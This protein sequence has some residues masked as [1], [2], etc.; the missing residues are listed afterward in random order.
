MNVNSN[1]MQDADRNIIHTIFDDAW[2]RMEYLRN[3]GNFALAA[4]VNVASVECYRY[5]LENLKTSDNIDVQYDRIRNKMRT[6]EAC[7]HGFIHEIRDPHEQVHYL[8]STYG[9]Y[10]EHLPDY[11]TLK[12]FLKTVADD[13]HEIEDLQHSLN[14][15]MRSTSL[16]ELS[17][18]VNEAAEPVRKKMKAQ[19][20]LPT[21][22]T[23]RKITPDL[24]ALKML[25]NTLK[26][27]AEARSK[28]PHANAI[29]S[30]ASP[31]EAT[32]VLLETTGSKGSLPAKSSISFAEA[33]GP[34]PTME[35]AYFCID[36]EKRILTG[37]FDGHGGGFVSKYV[38]EAFSKRFDLILIQ[39]QGN[40]H[41]AF[42][43]LF[44][45]IQKELKEKFK[46]ESHSAGSTAVVTYVDKASR[47]VYTATLGDSEA[48]LYR[49]IDGKMKSIKLS[50]VRDWSSQADANR[51]ANYYEK[52]I[53]AEKWPKRP[54]P[55]LLRSGI[56]EGVNVSRAFGDFYQT[57]NE[58]KP[59]IIGKPKITMNKM[60]EGDI[61]VL[62]C[63]GLKDYVPE[64][65]IIE[66]LEEAGNIN[67]AQRLVDYAIKVW[68]SRDNVSVIAIK[69]PEK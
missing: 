2:K 14:I 23:P 40:V 59:L 7:G 34:R 50:C 19:E 45:E 32:A 31:K 6:L 26:A 10:L 58:T 64:N 69:I 5:M 66:I 17:G 22:W 24:A 38:C 21:I 56:G 48:N 67:I 35:D 55:K 68:D 65:V 16:D 18:K 12:V 46:A 43:Q 25:K 51:I 11:K 9:P 3:H 49:N 33:R 39:C 8:E 54:N 57:G 60:Q 20:S 4:D 15:K 44:D 63:D 30:Y 42:E 1:S 52:P 36:D 41:Q 47:L 37:V 61:L 29:T 13:K 62:A 28:L 27:T 53:I